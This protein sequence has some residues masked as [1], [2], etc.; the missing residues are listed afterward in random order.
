MPTLPEWISEPMRF[1]S[2]FLLTEIAN[3]SDASA[4][5]PDS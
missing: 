1:T 3:R 4:P 5:L 2:L